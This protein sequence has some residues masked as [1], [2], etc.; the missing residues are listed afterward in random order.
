MRTIALPGS[1]PP[2]PVIG[3][4]TWGMGERRSQR[5]RE[6]EALRL[7]I[8]LGLTLI[9]TAELYGGGAAERVVGDAIADC[10]SQ[11]FI[12]TKVWP[13]HAAARGVWQAVSGSL[14]RLRTTY[15]D[16]VLLHWPNRQIPFAKTAQAFRSLQDDG[17]IRH[18]GVSNFDASRLRA[19]GSA[20]ITFNQI[21]Y[22][23]GDRRAEHS[24]LPYCR[25][26]QHILMAYSPLAHGHHR[27]WP[28]QEVLQEIATAH[29]VSIPQVALNWL[30]RST[31][32]IA[33][34]KAVSP[35]HVRDN[36]AA[37]T[38]E[39]TEREAERIA[40]AVPPSP[41]ELRPNLPES[42]AF[43]ALALGAVRLGAALGRMR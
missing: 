31:N 19:A 28:G 40:A 1:S 5:S 14:R 24:V 13:S 25:D 33:I 36:A 4:G 38:W 37:G 16:A 12:V 15:V 8:S 11:V 41:Q 26:H 30:V 20:D 9:D 21:P 42:T 27:G 43:F 6:V 3:Q 34:P 18:Y 39:L 2:L 10:R 32:V 17:L 29:G 35:K 7:G 22:S 23:L